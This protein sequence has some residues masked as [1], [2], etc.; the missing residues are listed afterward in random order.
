MDLREKLA[1]SFFAHSPILF[2]FDT[3]GHSDHYER[4]T[5]FTFP[6]DAAACCPTLAAA[7]AV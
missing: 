4:A 5:S 7:V 1:N 2:E 3:T 6:V